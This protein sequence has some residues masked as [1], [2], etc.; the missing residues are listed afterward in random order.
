ML[1]VLALAYWLLAAVGVHALRH[2]P[3]RLWYSNNK[4]GSCSLFTIGRTMLDRLNANILRLMNQLRG[5][6]LYEN[7]G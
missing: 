5:E 4:A 6:V 2:L 7:W 1:L 3:A